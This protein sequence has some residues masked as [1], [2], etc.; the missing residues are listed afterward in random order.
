MNETGS[1]FAGPPP[2]SRRRYTRTRRVAYKIAAPLVAGG[3]RLLWSTLRAKP[4][5]GEERA[6]ELVGTGQPVVPCMWH[7]QLLVG[8]WVMLRLHRV[9]MRMGWLISPSLEASAWRPD[10]EDPASDH[11]S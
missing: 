9:G 6:R 2:R 11:P 3:A 5:E 7:R 10:H 1:L 4:V 8:I